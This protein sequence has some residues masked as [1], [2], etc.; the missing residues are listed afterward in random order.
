VRCLRSN[1]LMPPEHLEIYWADISLLRATLNCMSAMEK[2]R[3]HDWRYVQ[4]LSY[5][6]FPLKT[7]KEMVQILRM[8]NGANDAELTGGQAERYTHYHKLSELDEQRL[9]ETRPIPPAGLILYKGSFAATLS[10]EFV[11]FVFED[12]QAQQFLEWSG[13]TWAPE[14][15]FWATLVHNLHLNAPG[16]FPGA[17][18]EYY[19][20]GNLQKLWISRYQVWYSGCEGTYTSGSCVFGVGDLPVLIKRPELIAH[21]FYQDF[22]PAA[23]YCLAKRQYERTYIEKQY[24]EFEKVPLDMEFYATLPAVQYQRMTDKERFSCAIVFQRNKG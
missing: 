14:E 16:R 18:L 24:W 23:F 8:F 10:R 6:D 1:M 21:K 3:D 11:R 20:H 2:R 5:N 22:E 15:Q 17:C 9:N 19:R 7:N 12:R 4:I 13:P